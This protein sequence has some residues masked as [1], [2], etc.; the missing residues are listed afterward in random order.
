MTRPVPRL[1]KPAHRAAKRLHGALYPALHRARQHPEV[2]DRLFGVRVPSDIEIAYDSTTVALRLALP[3]WWSHSGKILEVGTGSAGL[4]SGFV[5]KRTGKSVDAVEISEER[6]KTAT[7]VLASNGLKVNVVRSDLF[8]QVRGP[9]SLIFS[10][11]PYVPTEAGR[12]LNL[13]ERGRF[14][15]DRAWDGGADG[16]DIIRQILNGAAQMI[17]HNGIVLLGAQR[18]YISDEMMAQAARS[19]SLRLVHTHRFWWNPSHVWALGRSG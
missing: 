14:D 16:M 8:A 6:V 9:Y 12:Q 1:Y 7:R 2:V 19:A 13:T 15:S 4:L 17:T 11:P 18:F 5:A 10:N 3:K